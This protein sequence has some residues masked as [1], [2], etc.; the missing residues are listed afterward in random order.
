MA[1]LGVEPFAPERLSCGR[2]LQSA[3]WRTEEGG[4]EMGFG[5]PKMKI[6]GMI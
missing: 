1:Q 6:Y 3:C 4:G 5:F 2:R